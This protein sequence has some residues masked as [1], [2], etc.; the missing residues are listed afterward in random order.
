MFRNFSPFIGFLIWLIAVP[1]TLQSIIDIFGKLN[2]GNW[3]WWNY[4]LAVVGTLL[5][6]YGLYPLWKRYKQPLTS[7]NNLDKNAQLELAKI[8]AQNRHE[9]WSGGGS[10]ILF[11]ALFFGFFLAIILIGALVR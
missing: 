9:F 10:A 4:I 8:K 3:Q 5:I 7:N 11:L 6:I 1:N 2:I